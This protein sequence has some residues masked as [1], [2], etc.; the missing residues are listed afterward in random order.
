MEISQ[1]G[2]EAIVQ[3]EGLILKAYRDSRGILTIGVGHTGRMS[4]PRVSNG[5]VWTRDYA[6][7]ILRQDL[8]PT[9]AE[10]NRAVRLPMS[11]NQFDAYCSL[12]FNIGVGG[13]ASSSTVKMFNQGNVGAAA[14]DFLL[15][16]HPA[17]LLG[18]RKA[19]RAQ[20][21]T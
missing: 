13:F 16:D 3:R 12:C 11:Q 9:M 19:E 17:E 7:Q 8:G 21:L 18:R 4:P 15:W 5:I 14:D 20:F 6:I 10:V 2:L 1:A